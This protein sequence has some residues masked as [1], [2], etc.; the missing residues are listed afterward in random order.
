[1]NAVLS[2]RIFEPELS[3]LNCLADAL[4]KTEI[5]TDT[6]LFFVS[7]VHLLSIYLMGL[8]NM[9]FILSLFHK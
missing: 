8:S 9:Y 7:A 5:K 1:M 3:F 2:L 6:C 4:L